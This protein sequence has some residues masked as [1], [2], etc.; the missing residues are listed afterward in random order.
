MWSELV[1]VVSQ[2]LSNSTI[3][4]WD[5]YGNWCANHN[6]FFKLNNLIIYFASNAKPVNFTLTILL[7]FWNA[8]TWIEISNII[9]NHQQLHHNREVT[10]IKLIYWSTNCFT[11][12]IIITIHLMKARKCNILIVTNITDI[13][14][15]LQKLTNSANCNGSVKVAYF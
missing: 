12:Q 10:N 9:S 1:S 5:Y 8:W 13:M 4:Y 14:F 2:Y 6:L 3:N 11:R 7:R 15:L